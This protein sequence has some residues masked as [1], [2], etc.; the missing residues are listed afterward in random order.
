MAEETKPVE[1]PVAETTA[2]VAEPAVEAAPAAAEPAAAEPAVAAAEATTAE[3]AAEAAPAAEAPAAEE[4]KVEE[5][6]K[7]IEEGVLEA[8]GSTFPKYVA[9]ASHMC[10]DPYHANTSSPAGNSSTPRSI[11]GSVPMPSIPRICRAT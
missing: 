11:S 10:R 5:P 7:P 4:A 6:P 9:L 3:P 1:V 2:P 8:K